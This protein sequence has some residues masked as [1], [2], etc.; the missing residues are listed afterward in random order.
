MNFFLKEGKRK[1]R[2]KALKEIIIIIIG[3][4]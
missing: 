2:K 1:I 3:F 4:L